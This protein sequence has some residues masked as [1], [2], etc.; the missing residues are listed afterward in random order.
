MEPTVISQATEEPLTLAQAA[1]N[2]RVDPDDDYPASYPEAE[3]IQSLITA[4]RSALEN[5]LGVSLIAKTLEI[6]LD[7]WHHAHREHYQDGGFPYPYSS[8][9]FHIYQHAMHRRQRIELPYGPVRAIES[10]KYLDG[11]GADTTLAADQYRIATVRRMDMLVP[12]YGVSFPA[13]R[14]DFGSIR[15]RYS[16]GYPST[17]SPPETVPEPILQAMHLCIAHW[18]RNREAVDDGKLAELPL[19]VESLVWFYRRRML[20]L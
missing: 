4:A 9:Y 16:A 19:G 8:S 18:F 17:D 7:M 3:R 12:A 10:V 11:D 2:L 14:C 15:I 1:A 20:G 13:A 6:S 5:D